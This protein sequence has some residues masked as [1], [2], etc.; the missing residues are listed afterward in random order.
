MEARLTAGP[1]P[2]PNASLGPGVALGPPPAPWDAHAGW[3]TPPA[4]PAP[5][6]RTRRVLLAGLALLVVAA[7]LLRF[8]PPGQLGVAAV[9]A[10]VTD[11]TTVSILAG[12]PASIDPARHSDLGSAAYVSQLG[13]G[14][15]VAP[16]LGMDFL[17]GRSGILRPSLA[18]EYT[19]HDAMAAVGPNGSTEV[20]LVAISS[21]LR[22]NI[23]YSSMW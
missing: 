21:A 15:A 19:T 23:G 5:R 9:P 1:D 14:F 18:Y 22:F 8:W 3:G 4:P 11:P 12:K 16:R 2:D 17:V 7:M 20:T 10:S 13:T 6:S